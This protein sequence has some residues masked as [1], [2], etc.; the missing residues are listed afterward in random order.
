VADLLFAV[1]IV[2]T[3]L[4]GGSQFLRLLKTSQGVSITWFLFWEVFLV[5]NLVLTIRAHYRQP[6]RV[7][8]QTVLSYVAWTTVVTADLGLMLW[9]H[10]GLWTSSD[11][12]TSA[13]AGAG[14]AATLIVAYRRRLT[15]YD[16]V[17]RGYLALFFKAIPQLTLAYSI[18]KMG[19]AGVAGVAVV[20]GHV[21]ICTRLGQLWFAIREAG[22]E[23]NRIGSAISEVANEGSWIVATAVWLMR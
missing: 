21:T 1:Q 12:L 19:G 15:V 22:W 9:K 6:S 11:T 20:T 14:I 10:T 23:R 4:F 7:T 2:C 18:Y 3:L 5:L 16:P 13:V 8:L 17:V